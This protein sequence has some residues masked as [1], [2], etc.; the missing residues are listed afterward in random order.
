MCGC[1]L[2]YRLSWY[3]MFAPSLLHV[4]LNPCSHFNRAKAIEQVHLEQRGSIEFIPNIYIST[5]VQN[6]TKSSKE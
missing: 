1:Y 3:Y 6:G 4:Y 5:T 2:Q